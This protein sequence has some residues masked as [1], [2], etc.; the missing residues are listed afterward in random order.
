V[1][2]RALVFL[3]WSY[4]P[5]SFSLWS[6]LSCLINQTALIWSLRFT[7]CTPL[8]AMPPSWAW[9]Q[10]CFLH[11]FYVLID[12]CTPFCFY[13]IFCLIIYFIVK[14]LDCIF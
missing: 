8:W 1:H 6:D 10:I 13:F 2:L 12:I 5:I 7:S 3:I 14:T 9:A 11:P 4:A